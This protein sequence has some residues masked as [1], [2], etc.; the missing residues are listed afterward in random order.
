MGAWLA[1]R[2]VIRRE[3]L[4]PPEMYLPQTIVA[5]PFTSTTS[6]AWIDASELSAGYY[7][8]KMIGDDGGGTPQPTTIDVFV[9]ASFGMYAAPE[10]LTVPVGGAAQTSTITLT[11]T[12]SFTGVVSL[13]AQA[14]LFGAPV[15]DGSITAS[16][17]P[18]RIDCS[19]SSLTSTLSVGASSTATPGDYI[20]LVTG[21]DA[22]NNQTSCSV[23]ATVQTGSFTIA[24]NP[25][26]LDVSAGDETRDLTTVSLSGLGSFAGNATVTVIS[27]TDANG[28]DVT[29]GGGI[30]CWFTS[31]GDATSNPLAA[32]G[33]D[34]LNAI[35]GYDTAEG[36]YT[37][38]LT[39]ADASGNTSTTT[40]DLE[41]DAGFELYAEPTSLTIPAGGTGASIISAGSFGSP[42][43]SAIALEQP[44][45]FDMNGNPVIDGSVSVSL[46]QS[47]INVDDGSTSTAT[48][49]VGADVP[50]GSTYTVFITGAGPGGSESSAQISV[51]VANPSIT[52]D[53][54]PSPVSVNAGDTAGQT[55]T[56]SV[57]PSG[58]FTGLVSLSV[59]SVT[60]TAANGNALSGTMPMVSLSANSI[61][62]GPDGN[63]QSVPATISADA[64]VTPGTYTT[65]IAGVSG[66]VSGNATLTIM[67][68][69]ANSPTLTIDTTP[70][71]GDVDTPINLTCVGSLSGTY[72]WSAGTVWRS[73]TAN[74]TYNVYSGGDISFSWV[75][76]ESG[77]TDPASQ[78][79]TLQAT[80]GTPGYYIVQVNASDILSGTTY[81][82]TGYIGGNPP[83]GASQNAVRA[84]AVTPSVGAP[85]PSTPVDV[86][87][88]STLKILCNGI[89]VTDNNPSGPVVRGSSIKLSAQPPTGVSLIQ[90]MWTFSALASQSP[91][92]KTWNWHSAPFGMIYKIDQTPLA[93]SDYTNSVLNCCFMTKGQHMFARYTALGSDGQTYVGTGHVTV[94]DKIPKS[95]DTT[96]TINSYCYHWDQWGNKTKVIL[97][98]IKIA[99]PPDQ[100]IYPFTP[101]PDISKLAENAKGK[102]YFQPFPHYPYWHDYFST[103][104]IGD[105]GKP[106]TYWPDLM[107]LHRGND[108]PRRDGANFAFGAAGKS[109]GMDLLT[110]L[111]VAQGLSFGNTLQTLPNLPNLH[112]PDEQRCIELGFYW[113]SS[114]NRQAISNNAVI[115]VYDEYADTTDLPL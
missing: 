28:N 36:D 85:T 35:A 42:Y 37:I 7:A 59:G 26:W 53:A 83:S 15:T 112:P 60:G 74:G 17:V 75:D 67:V 48:V 14:Y 78:Y 109:A 87:G 6:F 99:I 22:S 4:T 113:W 33:Q 38:T 40:L 66:T 95:Q 57:I 106:T 82:A 30:D 114:P 52:L 88:T 100:V 20:V 49:T 31:S 92:I 2:T 65:T 56:V 76:A 97:P 90:G 104:S 27:I 89:D 72:E 107:L 34:T 45:I 73:D 94:Y 51:T 13:T 86:S 110:M 91:L 69:A 8:I 62:I 1:I 70:N 105:W 58:G 103:G 93:P 96:V 44:Q 63:G 47:S 81:T 115:T 79:A 77:E 98:Q 39:A 108:I 19:T 46:S 41:V 43:G 55:S 101:A 3:I 54:S 25:D 32:G 5:G 80:F 23:E 10:S 68:N 111:G 50:A 12:G 16:L 71:N 61:T 18:P 29:S 64:T 24:A 84:Y 21:T 11:P 9:Q 102:G